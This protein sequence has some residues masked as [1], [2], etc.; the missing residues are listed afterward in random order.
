MKVLR[1]SNHPSKNNHG[2]GLHPYKISE[3]NEFDTIFVC[4]LSTINDS[5]IEARNYKLISSK[6]FF[7]KR[8]T[9]SSFLKLVIFHLERIYG[10]IIFSLF[11]I[12]H[13]RKRNL[14]IVHIHS[15]MYLIIAFWG[16][17]TGKITCITY[18]GTDY[19]RIKDSNIYRILS[20]RFI[21][22]G[23][24]ISPH[25]I[26]K[27]KFNHDE[28][29]YIPN[30]VDT[31]FF[32][33]RK[34]N[35]KKI[36]LAVG[37]LKKEKSFYNLIIAFK[38]VSESINDYQLHIAGDGHLRSELELLVKK[39]G[40]E[41]K[42]FFCGNLNSE[43]LVNKYN[44]SE[45]FILSSYTE[46]FPK[47]VLE[48]IFSGCKVVATNVG[49]VKT[50]LPEKYVIPNDSVDNLKTFI[51]KIIKEKN[52]ELNIEELKIRYTWENVIKEYKKSYENNF[53]RDKRKM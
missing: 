30:G 44:S 17:L 25:M 40:L 9:E 31:K 49:S 20:K 29:K 35:R 21:D 45:C 52:Y 8:P 2:V 22:I 34:E 41:D 32:V 1:V 24:C 47:V 19:L 12:N 14:D 13:A 3:T 26:E 15:P 11:S 42:V 37:S 39:K 38:N 5:Y 23:F 10:L 43:E 50:F 4:P 53:K 18:H 51:I 6:V 7:K 46:G 48:A 33:N 27:M 28:V 16:K 36:L